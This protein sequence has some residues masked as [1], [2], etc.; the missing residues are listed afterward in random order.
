MYYP[1]QIMRQFIQT[2]S[3][4]PKRIFLIDSLGALLTSLLSV[5]VLLPFEALFGMPR[6]VL[7]FLS[8]TSLL[9][10]L[11]SLGCYWF[12]K[13]NWRPFLTLIWLANASYCCLTAGLIIAYYGRLTRLG[14]AYF[15]VEIVLIIVLIRVER[16]AFANLPPTS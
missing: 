14:V 8:G 11:Y 5:A 2:I 6:P 12:V 4:N 1:I 15:L 10:A 3:L 9:F 13:H 7:L 16:Q